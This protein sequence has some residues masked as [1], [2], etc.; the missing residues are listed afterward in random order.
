MLIN[1]SGV[2]SAHNQ[3]KEERNGWASKQ[4]GR[5]DVL[6][7][8]PSKFRMEQAWGWVITLGLWNRVP[9]FAFKL[10]QFKLQNTSYA[11]RA[12]VGNLNTARFSHWHLN[13]SDYVSG[14]FVVEKCL[15]SLSCFIAAA[16]AAHCTTSFATQTLE[17]P[18]CCSVPPTL[19]KYKS[20]MLWGT[21]GLSPQQSKISAFHVQVP[22]CIV[23]LGAKQLPEPQ[24]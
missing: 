6:T 5:K 18:R 21:E 8:E 2:L 14:K 4:L 22:I 12:V 19:L 11:A 1:V 23:F 15:A 16:A 13:S 20:G 10:S 24:K 7:L 17:L 3:R 9:A